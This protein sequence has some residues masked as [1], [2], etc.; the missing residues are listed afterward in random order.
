MS[1]AA[2]SG[3]FVGSLNFL[4]NIG[5]GVVFPLCAPVC[6]L[7]WGAG[8][9]ALA[10]LWE[11]DPY[12]AGRGRHSGAK[13]G[14]IA[15]AGGLLGLLVGIL[16]LYSLFGGQEMAGRITAALAAR[17]GVLMPGGDAAVVAQYLGLILVAAGVGALHMGVM[18]SAGA[19]GARLLEQ[20]WAH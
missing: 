13:A 5:L 20:R 14:A 6:A 10:V 3:L 17:Q 11:R 16:A 12:R 8:A 2:K 18:A 1:G 7:A 19:V 15:G 9:G 4:A